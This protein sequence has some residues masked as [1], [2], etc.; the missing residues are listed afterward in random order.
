VASCA[1]QVASDADRD[2]ADR[3]Q[4]ASDRDQATAD[5]ERS[6]PEHAPGADL[7]YL[8]SRRERDD[9]GRERYS[10]ASVRAGVVAERLTR[11]DLRD[12]IALLRDA[13]ADERDRNALAG[14][15]AASI[16]DGQAAQ[17]AGDEDSRAAFL[18]LR[19]QNA[20]IREEARSQRARA[21][22]DRAA[23]A[24]DRQRA[25][26]DRRDA[27]LDEL[28]GVF[29]RGAGELALAHEIA[30]ARRVGRPLVVAMIDIDRL[31][32][33]NDDAGHAAGDALLRGASRAVLATLRGYDITVRWGRD[34]FVCALSDVDLATASERLV[35]MQATLDE[36][37]PGASISSG[38]ADLRPG[39]TL[40]AVI[41]RAD[42][43]LYEA[44][45][46]R[47]P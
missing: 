43:A 37:N 14:D 46:R 15:Q 2:L 31:K 34:E 39:D 6:R 10:T 13:S 25:A 12:E 4:A 1:D 11:A 40:E 28:S 5:R 36:M 20:A 44:K 9:A 16:R 22:D 23:A 21:A 35:Q 7:D 30:R 24:A 33:V 47:G 32:A 45:S 18:A 8:R 3:D 29:R 17:W 38:L 19:E 41:G 26:A 42:A 27:G